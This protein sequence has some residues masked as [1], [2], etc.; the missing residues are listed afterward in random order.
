M[1]QAEQGLS[2]LE[3]HGLLEEAV[4]GTNRFVRAVP[5]AAAVDTLERQWAEMLRSR[6]GAL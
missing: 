6:A 1:P 4:R 3:R 5:P 2:A